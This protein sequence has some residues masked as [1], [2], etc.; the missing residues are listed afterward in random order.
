MSKYKPLGFRQNT[1]CSF[2]TKIYADCYNASAKSIAL[3]IKVIDHLKCSGNGKKIAILGDIGEIDGFEDDIYRNIAKSVSDSSIDVLI[4]Y[5][6]NSRKI[7]DFLA[8]DMVC[9][10]ENN[11]SDLVKMIKSVHKRGDCILF[12]ASRSMHLDVAIKK[13]FP[14]AFIKGMLPVFWAYFKWTL[15][16]L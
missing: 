12:K 4:T 6:E 11:M 10:Q 5:G 15:R 7:R 9:Y 2:G 8:R 13:A 1:Y 3:A 14:F 16:T